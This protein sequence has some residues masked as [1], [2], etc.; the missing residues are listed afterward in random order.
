MSEVKRWYSSKVDWWL[1]L[2]LA[3][4]PVIAL[5]RVAAGGGMFEP[6]VLLVVYVGLVFPMRYGI[7]G[8]FLVIRSGLLRRRIPLASITRVAPSRN[9]LSSPALSLDRLEIRHGGLSRRTLISPAE[10]SHFIVDLAFAARLRR[11]QSG[12]LVR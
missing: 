8:D 2:L 4:A 12:G 3:I 7:S 6:L 1:A 5:A 10:R 11:D 9:P